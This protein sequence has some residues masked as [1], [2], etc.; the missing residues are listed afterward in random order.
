MHQLLG[1]T[2]LHIASAATPDVAAQYYH[3]ATELQSAAMSGFKVHQTRIDEDSAFAVLVFSSLV[4]LHVLADH[5]RT[6]DL[7]NNDFLNHFLHTVRLMQGV[8][9]LVVNE[10]WERIRTRPEVGPFLDVEHVG[11]PYDSPQPVKQLRNLLEEPA[12]LGED[13]VAAYSIAIDHIEWIYALTG[14]P[15]KSYRTVRMIMAWPVRSSPEY[16][17]LV[18]QRRPEALIILAYYAVALHF[19]KD[20]WVVRDTGVRLLNAI[21]ANLGSYWSSW[22]DWP[23]EIIASFP[24][25]AQQSPGADDADEDDDAGMTNSFNLDPLMEQNMA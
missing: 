21:D 15:Y 8:R 11:P 18:D 25:T 3:R 22:L 1:I 7:G 19:Y 16:L 9:I 20:S 13:A 23:K 14:V 10:W 12:M 5:S 6:Y 4:G 17:T 24:S 2:A